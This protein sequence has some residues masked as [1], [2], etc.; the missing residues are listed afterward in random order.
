MLSASVPRGAIVTVDATDGNVGVEEA[1]GNVGVD[2]AGGNVN[3]AFKDVA[4]ASVCSEHRTALQYRP[5]VQCT[6]HLN[7][8]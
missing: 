6:C 1:D 4:T 8:A 7:K 2:A 5:T 3:V